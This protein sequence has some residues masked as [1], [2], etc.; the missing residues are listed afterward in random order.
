MPVALVL[1]FRGNDG[2][3]V[4][5]NGQFRRRRKSASGPAPSVRRGRRR[6]ARSRN[7]CVPRGR[8]RAAF[9]LYTHADRNAADF[10]GPRGLRCAQRARTAALAATSRR[11]RGWDAADGGGDRRTQISGAGN[12]RGGQGGECRRLPVPRARSRLD[13][14]GWPMSRRN[15]L[16]IIAPDQIWPIGLATPRPAMSGAELHRLEHR[17]YSQLGVDAARGRDADRPDHRRGRRSD[18]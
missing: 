5:S 11:Q 17:W 4:A 7:G 6:C 2:N 18:R 10:R 14:R 13:G 12:G 8:A 1:R 9:A 16:G 3:T 15:A